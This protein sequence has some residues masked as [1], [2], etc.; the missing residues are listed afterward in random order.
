MIRYYVY[1]L[2]STTNFTVDNVSFKRISNYK[3]NVQIIANKHKDQLTF[4]A[5]ESASKSSKF[6]SGNHVTSVND[7]MIL[8]SLAQSR[9]IFYP[10]ARNTETKKEW[11]MSLGGKRQESGYIIISEDEIESYLNT[12]LNQIRKPDLLKEKGLDLS[13]F[14]WLEAIYANRPLETKFISGFI[15]LE[16][17][18][19]AH[20]NYK[21][22][23]NNG[24]RMK[25]EVLANSY[26][27]GFMDSP[28]IKDWTA[29]RN[30][31]MHE[32][33]TKSLEKKKKISREER[34][35]R[36]F[37]LVRSVQIALIDLLGFPT[38]AQRQ[39]KI[40]EIKNPCVK[41]YKVNGPFSIPT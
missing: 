24:V 39:N 20:A 37:Q 31:Y 29:I 1:N 7:M 13:I 11:G 18:A 2:E 40:S 4:Y 6:F 26:G 5:I 34:D 22:I 23:K 35:T 36:Y 41:V 16:I 17:L 14:W 9:N 19:N 38:F 27:W 3:R 32:G 10:K 28:L 33:T 21:N 30:S 8:L 25:I 15:A 12:A